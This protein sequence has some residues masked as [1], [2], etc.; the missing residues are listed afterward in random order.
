[1]P[2]T[3]TSQWFAAAVA[4]PIKKPTNSTSFRAACSLYSVLIK[5]TIKARP[6]DW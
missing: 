2:R 1:M 3:E 4:I 5:L 6:S